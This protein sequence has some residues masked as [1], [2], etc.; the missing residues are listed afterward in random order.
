MLKLVGP[1]ISYDFTQVW[2][3]YSYKIFYEFKYTAVRFREKITFVLFYSFIT[4][5]APF[6]CTWPNINLLF[7]HCTEYNNNN[8]LSVVTVFYNERT[9]PLGV[10]KLFT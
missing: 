8:K 1:N 3:G 6:I 10:S 4:F 7:R 5:E 9:S 2:R